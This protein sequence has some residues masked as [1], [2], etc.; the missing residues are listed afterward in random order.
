MS[1]TSPV[2]PFKPL[3]DERYD[4]LFKLL[5]VGDSAVG[6]TSLLQQFCFERFS[7]DQKSTIGVEFY[8]KTIA[9]ADQV[10]KCQCW[11]TA[12]QE[13]Y[14]SVTPSFY[15]GALGVVI[16][17][18]STFVKS[19]ENVQFWL[20]QIQQYCPSAK[21][22]LLSNKTDLP[23]LRAVPLDVAQTYAEEQNL[24][25]VE[26]SAKDLT[27]V[28]SAFTTLTSLILADKNVTS[29]AQETFSSSTSQPH[30]DQKPPS[31]SNVIKL[32][33]DQQ[34][35]KKK[36]SKLDKWGIS[37]KVGK[38]EQKIGSHGKCC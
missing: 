13:R 26:A 21:L 3:V 35:E 25:F 27:S 2:A 16:V 10:V 14:R 9:I 24:A 31:L 30:P 29:M 33:I 18:D 15:R 1:S 6:K 5:V 22:L 34:K 8:T 32:K 19:F 37:R 17:Y 23:D 4:Y 38:Q 20:N 36:L 7:L 28:T 12:G 11:D